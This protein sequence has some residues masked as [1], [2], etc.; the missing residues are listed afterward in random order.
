M[1][2]AAGI[3]FPDVRYQYF[4]TLKASQY[5]ISPLPALN[6]IHIQPGNVFWARFA[7]LGVLKHMNY[8]QD[9]SQLS[10]MVDESVANLTTQ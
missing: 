10:R 7:K 5:I 4:L 2:C 8:L 6:E 3:P 1:V 9:L